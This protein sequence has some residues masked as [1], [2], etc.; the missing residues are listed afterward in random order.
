MLLALFGI[1]LAGLAVYLKKNLNRFGWAAFVLV[2][3]LGFYTVPVMLYPFSIVMAWLGLSWLAHDVS[4]AHARSSLVYWLG[5]VLVVGL[6]TFLLYLPVIMRSGLDA[7]VANRWVEALEWHEF[8]ANLPVRALNTW[9][10]WQRG[11]PGQGGVL[12]IAGIGIG[13]V[14]DLGSMVTWRRQ[15]AQHQFSP[16]QPALHLV[17]AERTQGPHRIPTLLAALL[18]LGLLLPLQRV[19]PLAKVWVFLQPWFLFWSA[20]GWVKL[21]RSGW[22]VFTLTLSSLGFRLE[23][24]QPEG[25]PGPP[26]LDAAIIGVII[27]LSGALAWNSLVN[28][29]FQNT[30]DPEAVGVSEETALFLRGQ[31]QTGDAVVVV[32]PVNYP[33]RYYFLRYGMF[34]E[35]IFQPEKGNGPLRLLVVVSRAADQTLE[36]VLARARAPSSFEPAAAQ[37]IYRYRSS[38]VYLVPR[39]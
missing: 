33:L 10:I 23:S 26:W 11:L 3:V 37:E 7:L 9:E 14:L 25:R 38:L 8:I 20:S 28:T 30:I 35:A 34:Q 16:L 27:C 4:K 22:K 32:F 1:L 13:L 19:A 18:A 5:S 17:Q 12:L 31:L 15:D 29:S 24:S 39:R 36:N 21:V 2:S 6:L